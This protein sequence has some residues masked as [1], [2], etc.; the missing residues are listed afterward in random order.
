M[1]P[2][3]T[4]WLAA[5][6]LASVG[7]GTVW[8][9]SAEPQLSPEARALVAPVHAGYVKVEAD[10]AML[11]P[12]KDDRERLERMYDLDQA[13]R[14]VVAKIDLSV[15]PLAERK[16][17]YNV[18]WNEIN[19]HDLADQ[20]ELKEIVARDG[21]ITTTKFGVKASKA[22]FAIVQ[23]AVNDPDLMRA[24]LAQLGPLAAKGEVDGTDYARMYDRVALEFDH[25]PQRYGSQL[26]C[27][28]GVWRP[29]TL[30]DP[31]RVDER[32]KAI[33][34]RQTEAEFLK[35]RVGWACN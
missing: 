21:W 28:G 29:R 30:E 12:P 27:H 3:R 32:R 15:L 13:A 9:A 23:H 26:G 22:A 34:Y 25:K 1:K 24:T 5:F 6:A 11:P 31:E 35:R 33:G 18:M 7:L 19:A 10:Q 20:K 17:A 16:V 14:V 8:L 4:A 2:A